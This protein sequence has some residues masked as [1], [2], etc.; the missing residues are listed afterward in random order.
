MKIFP[1][2]IAMRGSF[3]RQI[4][5]AFVVGFFLLITAF[6]VYLVNRERG[7]LY[8]DSVDETTGLAESLAVSS[9]SW[10][11]AN[12]VAGLQEVVGSFQDYPALRYAMVISP[13]GRVLAHNDATKIGQFIS[14][15]KSLAL[16]MSH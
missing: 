13:T 10:V 7:H 3:K 4:I 5:L 1:S 16:L 6:A 2:A 14:D 9:L 8:H 12:D 15:E 11:L